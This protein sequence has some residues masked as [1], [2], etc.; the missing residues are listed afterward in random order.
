MIVMQNNKSKKK[1]IERFLWVRGLTELQLKFKLEEWSGALAPYV[2]LEYGVENS[3]IKI[4]LF[5]E[6]ED[7]C[8]LRNLLS[9]YIGELSRV[10]CECTL[11]RDDIFPEVALSDELQKRGW[12]I[13]T[14][15]SCTGGRIGSILTRHA[16]SS[17]YYKGSVVA[18]C[19]EVKSNV[20]GVSREVLSTV[21][22]VSAPVVEEMAE[23]VVKLLKTDIGVAV[24]GIAGPGGGSKEKPVGMVWLAVSDGKKTKS[25]CCYFGA[26]REENMKKIVFEAI[27]LA[28]EFVENK[29]DCTFAP[30]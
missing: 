14:A 1:T 17:C 7:E 18:Y 10:F 29:K 21:G 27:F 23:G 8:F 16:G 12:T 2:R 22:A 6:H 3:N 19:N 15:E 30:R 25:E 5:G 11:L 24:S 20:L 28:K 9:E 13:S 4:S 26:E